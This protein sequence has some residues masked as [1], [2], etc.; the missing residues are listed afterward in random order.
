MLLVGLFAEGDIGR[1]VLLK[2][3]DATAVYRGNR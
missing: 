1:K 3:D 2:M